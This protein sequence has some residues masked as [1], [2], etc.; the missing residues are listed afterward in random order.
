MEPAIAL[1]IESLREHGKPVPRPERKAT[2][3]EVA[4]QS[5]PTCR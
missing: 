5:I 4:A 1:H 2:V 3:I